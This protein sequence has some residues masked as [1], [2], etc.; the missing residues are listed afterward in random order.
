MIKYT[1]DLFQKKSVHLIEHIVQF[2]IVSEEIDFL[3]F[4]TIDEYVLDKS[5]LYIENIF[6]V[7]YTVQQ[8]LIDYNV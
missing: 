3:G 5:K 4:D 1:V 6:D 7:L 2:H 8:E